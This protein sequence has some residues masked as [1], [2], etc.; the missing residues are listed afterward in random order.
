MALVIDWMRMLASARMGAPPTD[1]APAAT[2][3]SSAVPRLATTPGTVPLAT[4][5]SS[6]SCNALVIPRHLPA[7]Y[8][9][10]SARLVAE[11]RERLSPDGDDIS[12]HRH[13]EHLDALGQAGRRRLASPRGELLATSTC[14]GHWPRRGW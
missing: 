3:L 6:R 12:S 11:T 8:S 10:V 9:V 1:I 4:C 7:T 14:S 13:V 5:R 2:I